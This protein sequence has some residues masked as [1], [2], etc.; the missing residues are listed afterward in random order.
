MYYAGHG[1]MK[2]AYTHIV[3]N[4][5]NETERLYPWEI[6][7]NYLSAFKNTYTFSFLDCCRVEISDEELIKKLLVKKEM[8]KHQHDIHHIDHHAE[9][10]ANAVM[11]G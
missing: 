2:G 8:K 9:I 11:P 7:I 5:P 3:L 10:V 1:E 4:D 6:N